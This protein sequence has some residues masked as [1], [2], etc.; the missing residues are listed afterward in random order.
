MRT[1][2]LIN[3]KNGSRPRSSKLLHTTVG[4]WTS[5]YS[6]QKSGTYMIVCSL[7]R[8]ETLAL[9]WPKC[10]RSSKPVGPPALLPLIRVYST[11]PWTTIRGMY[12][13]IQNQF[14]KHS[15]IICTSFFFLS[16]SLNIVLI[17]L[18]LLIE[19]PFSLSACG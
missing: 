3:P 9:S 13:I 8:E 5:W 15:R 14:A 2:M 17:Y 6:S 7:S 12:R 1:Y 10:G 19:L 18:H 11:N 16:G 4:A